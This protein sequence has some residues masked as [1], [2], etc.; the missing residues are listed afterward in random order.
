MTST[1]P[2]VPER[3]RRP[4]TRGLG[5]YLYLAPAVLFVAATTIYPL[6]YNVSLSL[7]DATMQNFVA[8]RLSY[9]GAAN[10]ATV[11]ADGS[12]WVGL[13]TSLIYTLGTIVLM[14]IIG[15]ALALLLQRPYP[16]RNLIRAMLFLPYVLP[17]VVGANV[18]RWLLDGSYGL[19]NE[20]LLRIGI[21][22]APVFWLGNPDTALL[23]VII[24]TAWTMAPFAMLLLVAG[25]QGIPAGLHSA[26]A[27]DGAVGIRRFFAVTLPLLR[28]V[29]LVV[30][31]LGFIYTFRTF[32]TIFIMT[33]GGPGDATT[34]L[35]IMA[36]QQA[37]VSFDLGSG[38]A[39]NTLMLIIPTVLALLYFRATRSEDVR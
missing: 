10:Y 7:Y 33:R 29:T 27:L 28:P 36:Y 39:I 38:A 25:L 30:A 2:A 24:A 4:R 8:G 6:Y 15:M 11:L 14:L 19:F 23:A 9:I 5:R 35:P 37:F 34:V 26:S 18:W 13:R 20:L 21:I 16:G 17:S 3:R 31:L 12:L 1:A 32:D 22:R